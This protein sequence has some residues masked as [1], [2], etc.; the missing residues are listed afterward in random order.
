VTTANG[1]ARGQADDRYRLRGVD[2]TRKLVEKDD[3][4]E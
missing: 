4:D 3:D 2:P 1:G